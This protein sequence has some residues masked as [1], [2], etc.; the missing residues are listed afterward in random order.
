MG[1]PP[2]THVVFAESVSEW[3]GKEETVGQSGCNA[4]FTAFNGEELR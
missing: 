4:V 2:E 1:L 3:T